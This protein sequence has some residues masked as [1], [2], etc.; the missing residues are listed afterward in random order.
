MVFGKQGPTQR[1]QE[2]QPLGQAEANLTASQPAKLPI[3]PM[4]SATDQPGGEPVTIK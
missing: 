2:S 1:Q 3:S 4:T